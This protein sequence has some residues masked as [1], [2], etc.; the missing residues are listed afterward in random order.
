MP[1]FNIQS[2][3]SD[4]N[5]RGEVPSDLAEQK[6]EYGLET[7]T[8]DHFIILSSSSPFFVLNDLRLAIGSGGEWIG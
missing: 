4:L 7:G 8:E 1:F 3:T 6:T 5:E 2:V